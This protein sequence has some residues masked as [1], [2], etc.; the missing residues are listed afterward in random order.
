MPEYFFDINDGG[1]ARDVISAEYADL[2]EVRRAAMQLLPD[3]VRDDVSDHQDEHS[4]SVSVRD[5]NGK[6]IFAASLKLWI[7]R[8][9]E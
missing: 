6:S 8:L 7:K 1:P 5:A 3:I 4:L 2:A 9:S